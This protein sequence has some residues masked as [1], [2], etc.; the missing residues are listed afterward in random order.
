MVPTLKDSS[1]RLERLGFRCGAKGTHSSRNMMYGDLQT[2]FD[3]L[4]EGATR[5]NYRQAI[6]DENV[7]GKPTA[8]SRKRSFEHLGALYALDPEVPLF[9]Y[10]GFLWNRDEAGRALIA[11]FTAYA[12]D[13]L[14][15][16]TAESIL[17]ASPSDRVPREAFVEVLG[18][19]TGERFSEN[20]LEKIVGTT[21]SS[22]CTGGYLEGVHKRVRRSPEITPGAAA[23]ALFASYL[24]GFRGERM[25]TSRWGRL[26]DKPLHERKEAAREAARRGWLNY[27]EAGGVVE[28]TFPEL[29]TQDEEKLSRESD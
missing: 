7:L 18:R 10:M 3:S 19:E 13:P 4:P 25:F 15:R 22:W 29:L 20:V 9:R 28:V 6:V 12:R 1:E 2:L 23:M 16:T 24:E 21:T 8:S 17:K 27:R 14:L 26:L 11:F 5:S